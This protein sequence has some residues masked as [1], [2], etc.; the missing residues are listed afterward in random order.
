MQ[1]V[2]RVRLFK[3]IED[4]TLKSKKMIL[5]RTKQIK[6][7]SLVHAASMEPNNLLWARIFRFFSVDAA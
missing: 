3:K 4:W 7:R 6:P 2:L 5:R 1:F